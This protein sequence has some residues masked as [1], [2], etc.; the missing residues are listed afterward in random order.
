MINDTG[1]TIMKL[2]R[3]LLAF[4]LLTSLGCDPDLGNFTLPSELLTV[5]VMTVGENL[6]ADGY[7]LSITSEFDAAIGI[8]ESRTFSVL[9]IDITI[10][11]RGVADNCAVANN[12]RTIDVNRPTTTTFVVECS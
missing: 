6:D 2:S 7:T 4:G 9:R 3:L 12:P 10:E 1:K 5:T 8:N 11:L